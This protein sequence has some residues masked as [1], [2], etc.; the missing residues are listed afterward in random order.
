MNSRPPLFDFYAPQRPVQGLISIPH[1]G[2]EIP[3]D[4]QSFLTANEHHRNQDV[5]LAVDQLIDISLLNHHGIGVLVS[6][7]HRTAV[8]LNRAPEVA[9][10]NWKKNSHQKELVIQEPDEILRQKLLE[11]FYKPYYIMLSAL[12]KSAP[13]SLVVDLHSMP[14]TATEYHLKINPQQKKERPSFCLSDL[15]GQSA[16]IEVMQK[17][18]GQLQEQWPETTINDPYFGGYVTQYIHRQF[19]QTDNL[20]IEINRALYMNEEEL[21]LKDDNTIEEFKQSLTDQL[22]K[23]Y[24]WYQK[25]S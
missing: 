9:V 5:D 12:I 19:P 14:S 25:R 2:L 21:K 18:Q 8:D 24:S 3:Q 4:F 17:I 6:R 15:K 13:H 16:K 22:I 10:L 20:Q 1:S 23:I 7:V 11:Q